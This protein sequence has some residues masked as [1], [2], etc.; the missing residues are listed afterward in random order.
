MPIQQ[1]EPQFKRTCLENGQVEIR[2]VMPATSADLEVDLRGAEARK[3]MSRWVLALASGLATVC[4]LDLT[5][6][7][8]MIHAAIIDNVDQETILR[9]IREKRCTPETLVSDPP[10]DLDPEILRVMLADLLDSGVVYVDGYLKCAGD[11]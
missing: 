4:G 8:Y 2:I 7:L 6:P 1:P 10:D 5:Q 3:E 11:N 9:T